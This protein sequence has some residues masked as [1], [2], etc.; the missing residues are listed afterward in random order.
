ML[1]FVYEMR[2]TL[3]GRIIGQYSARNKDQNLVGHF[4]RF[5]DG[6]FIGYCIAVPL[7]MHGKFGRS[8]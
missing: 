7:K 8:H 1:N 3:C 5:E 2:I 4:L 6:Y